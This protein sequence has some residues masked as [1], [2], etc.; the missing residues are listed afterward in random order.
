M[1]EINGHGAELSYGQPLPGYTLVKVIYTD[2]KF[3]YEMY[4]NTLLEEGWGLGIGDP[5]FLFDKDPVPDYLPRPNYNFIPDSI[6]D[7]L[8]EVEKHYEERLAAVDYRSIMFLYDAARKVGYNSKEDGLLG[9]WLCDYLY[10]YLLKIDYKPHYASLKKE[11]VCG[12]IDYWLDFNQ[13]SLTTK[14]NT[15]NTH[16]VIYRNEKIIYIYNIPIDLVNLDHYYENID[17]LINQIRR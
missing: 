15:S 9:Y 1:S 4:G 11:N 8:W 10:Y 13:L 16:K 6:T 3:P 7:P 12:D 17:T 5:V 2:K 14:L